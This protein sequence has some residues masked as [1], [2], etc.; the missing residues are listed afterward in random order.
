MSSQACT[1]EIRFC[2]LFVLMFC[3][4]L[5]HFF[6]N[7]KSSPRPDFQLELIVRL[8]QKWIFLLRVTCAMNTDLQI[9]STYKIQICFRLNGCLVKLSVERQI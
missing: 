3:E 5:Y 4:L 1:Y 2:Y 6:L 8:S 7:L 9:L